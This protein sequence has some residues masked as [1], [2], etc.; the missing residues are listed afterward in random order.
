MGKRI[1]VSFLAFVIFI[2]GGCKSH[3]NASNEKSIPVRVLELHPDSISSYVEITGSL[4]AG[5]DALVLSKTSE[6]LE[7]I[8]KPAGS[9]VR[10]NDIIA[11]LKNSMLKQSLLQAQAGLNSAKAR[12][13]NVKSDF[14][15]YQKLF[16]AK[17]ISVQQWQKIKSA[18]EEAEAGLQQMQA[19][20]AQAKERYEDSFIKAPFSGIVG[21]IYYDVGQMVPMGRPVAKIIN[22]RL[23]KAKLYVPDLYFKKFKIDQEVQ[24]QFP[25]IPKKTFKGRI[26]RVDPAIDPMSR[27]FLTEV[28]L[29]N[30]NQDLTS[31]LYGV[32]KINIASA[33]QTLIVPDN[34]IL[35]RTEVKVDKRTGQ[36]YSVKKYFVFTVENNRAKLRPI[37]KGL[38]YGNRVQ[39]VKGLKAGDQV[40]VVGQFTVK[41]G[42]K[43][44]IQEQ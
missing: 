12:F 44:H 33:H 11:R 5:K 4:E 29:E 32:F 23:M 3:K 21:S 34:A 42:Q 18:M 20:F 40:I 14:E 37:Q 22:P 28:V 25:A 35:T 6:R 7:S 10:K 17:A 38:A 26:V 16:K 27:T 2:F 31:G 19:A 36:T 9:S 1:I 15:R 30:K 8:L 41:E 24:A 43:V 39:I 13:A